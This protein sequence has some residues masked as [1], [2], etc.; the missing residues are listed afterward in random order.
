M[1]VQTCP[2]PGVRAQEDE[3]GARRHAASG[4]HHSGGIGGE[5]GV[6]VGIRFMGVVC[7]GLHVD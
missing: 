6:W 4:D 5:G 3:K 2:A 7:L 1:Q